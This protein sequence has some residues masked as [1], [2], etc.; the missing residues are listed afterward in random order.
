M[1]YIAVITFIA[2]SILLQSNAKADFYIENG[3][4]GVGMWRILESADREGL[5]LSVESNELSS[6]YDTRLIAL[7]VIADKGQ[8]YYAL[9]ISKDL[10]E[11]EQFAFGIATHIGFVEEERRLGNELEFFSK[12]YAD[13][14][15]SN[16]NSARLE[17]GHVSNAGTGE[18]NPGSENL[19]LSWVHRF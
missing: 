4:V 7:A 19:T 6:F 5:H 18:R 15:F 13:Y 17:F 1:K 9:G 10:W 14:R 8:R 3:V 16:V 12:V 11:T 2:L